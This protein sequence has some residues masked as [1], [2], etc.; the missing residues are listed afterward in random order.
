MSKKSTMT[1]LNLGTAL[2]ELSELGVLDVFIYYNG[3]GDSGEISEIGLRYKQSMQ[4]KKKDE[5]YPE[6]WDEL[7]EALEEWAYAR[8]EDEADWYNNEGGEGNIQIQVPSGEYTL[9]HGIREMHYNDSTGDL[10][11]EEFFKED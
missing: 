7:R 1:K 9:H 3:S 4:E 5:K 2:L 6:K 11:E 10:K 8:L